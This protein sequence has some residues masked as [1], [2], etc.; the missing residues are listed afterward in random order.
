MDFVFIL[1]E[2]PMGLGDIKTVVYGKAIYQKLLLYMLR[3][4]YQLGI[5]MEKLDV[6]TDREEK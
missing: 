2:E 5:Q 3:L 4:Q 6:Q 1:K